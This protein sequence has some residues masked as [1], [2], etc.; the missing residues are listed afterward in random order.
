MI[1]VWY[2]MGSDLE[3]VTKGAPQGSALGPF[4]YNIITNDLLLLMEK[5]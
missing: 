4:M 2:K 3:M 1:E 5:A